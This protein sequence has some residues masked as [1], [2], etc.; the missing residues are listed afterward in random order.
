VQ[1][2]ESI[3]PYHAITNIFAVGCPALLY[4]LCALNTLVKLTPDDPKYI[5]QPSVVPAV[6][7]PIPVIVIPA[8]EPTAVGKSIEDT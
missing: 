1:K 2:Q 3:Q 5:E 7:E 8:D 6:G 4:T